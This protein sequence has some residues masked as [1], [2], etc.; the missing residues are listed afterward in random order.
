M[1]IME[2]Q[3]YLVLQYDS[4]LK[5]YRLNLLLEL[6][7]VLLSW[8]SNSRISPI[9]QI[10]KIKGEKAVTSLPDFSHLLF[11]GP[12]KPI[13]LK[14]Q[15][16]SHCSI[17]LTYGLYNLIVCTENKNTAKKILRWAKKKKVRYEYWVV[18]DGVRITYEQSS[19]DYS[20]RDWKLSLSDLSTKKYCGELTETIKE[21]CV[22]MSTTLSRANASDP[23]LT[24]NLIDSH[25]HILDILNKLSED[26]GLLRHDINSLMTKV[27]AGLSRFSSQT[28]SGSSP[29]TDTECHYWIHSLLGTGTANV[30][31][32]KIFDFIFQ[33]IGSF[34]IPA[35][36]ENLKGN[37]LDLSLGFDDEFWYTDHLIGVEKISSEKDEEPFPLFT[38]FSGRD[39]FKST[40]T[41]LSAPLTTVTSCN[42]RLW[43]L[44]TLTHEISHLFIKGCLSVLY[45]VVTSDEELEQTR[46]LWDKEI[47]DLTGTEQLRKYLVGGIASIYMADSGKEPKG[48]IKNNESLRVIL[49]KYYFEVEEIMAHVFDFLYFYQGKPEHYIEGIWLS[50]SVIPSISN[51]VP[52]YVFRSLSAVAALY[53]RKRE[54]PETL[55]FRKVLKILKGLKAK[56]EDIQ[57][58]SEAVK[59]LEEDWDE[60]QELKFAARTVL[61]SI[62]RTF[63]YSESLSARLFK[64]T[65]QSGGR[66]RKGGY[67]KKLYI[68]DDL[69]IDNPLR[70]ISKYV[71]DVEPS[72]AKSLWILNN[73]CFNNSKKWI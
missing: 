55:A 17:W 26:N 71:K 72:P 49:D 11:L 13:L 59:L 1:K 56:H 70:F 60:Q 52:D 66:S 43:D 65:K 38:Y 50:W 47:A 61:T 28:F 27:N 69:L 5:K 37:E 68:L 57:Y 63:F 24:Q 15:I 40:Q 10:Q 33:K 9:Y 46:S 41:T 45:P 2:R 16:D 6:K 64:E 31:L 73:I 29:I 21:Y 35:R 7:E 53:L 51:R 34:N 48:E 62:V 67:P 44:K 3:N 39:G 23:F 36:I 42:S 58:I 22:L 14:G 30:A 25:Y 12:L 20:K 54:N 4:N 18:Q 8:S 32:N 19:L